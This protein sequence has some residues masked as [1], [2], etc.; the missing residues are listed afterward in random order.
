MANLRQPGARSPTLESLQD[1]R[2]E[3]ALYL[4]PLTLRTKQD[5]EQGI[6]S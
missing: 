1:F 2:E 3:L 6:F 5:T 4:L